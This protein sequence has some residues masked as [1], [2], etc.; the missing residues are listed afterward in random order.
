MVVTG[1]VFGRGLGASFHHHNDL[2]SRPQLQPPDVNQSG[3]P[4]YLE[5]RTDLESQPRELKRISRGQGVN[6]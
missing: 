6:R 3:R 4:Y 5:P 1:A 2:Q